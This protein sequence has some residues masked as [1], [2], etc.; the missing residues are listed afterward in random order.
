MRFHHIA[1]SLIAGLLCAA[2]VSAQTSDEPWS[3][4]QDRLKAG[5]K[6]TVNTGDGRESRGRFVAGRED[7]VVLRMGEQ[8][9]SVPW[10]DVNRVRRRQN[11][12]LLGAIIGT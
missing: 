2:T 6:L 8:D 12:V 5:D 4:L 1:A 11:G 3:T 10:A 9:V 7:A